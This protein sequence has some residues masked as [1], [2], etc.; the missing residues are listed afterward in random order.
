MFGGKFEPSRYQKSTKKPSKKGS[1]KKDGK[2][3]RLEATLK[4]LGAVSADLGGSAEEPARDRVDEQRH[5]P[6]AKL[7]VFTVKTTNHKP[8][9]TVYCIGPRA[10]D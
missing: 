4:R 10:H 1:K 8:M 6:P 5:V 7:T 9:S 2:K 3:R